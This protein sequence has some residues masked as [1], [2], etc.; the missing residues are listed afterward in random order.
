[1]T[2]EYY[3]NALIC[4]LLLRVIVIGGSLADALALSAF[5]LYLAVTQYVSVKRWQN[6]ADDI[7]KKIEDLVQQMEQSKKNLQSKDDEMFKELQ[8][9]SAKVDQVKM[10]VSLS[11]GIRK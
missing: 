10:G 5:A 11:Q 6:D 3:L 9:V 2:R 7:N 4:L 1:M 8:I